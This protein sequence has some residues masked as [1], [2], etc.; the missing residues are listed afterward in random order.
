MGW[1][2]VVI[3]LRLIDFEHT[4]FALPFAYLGAFLAVGGVPTA[5][6]FWWITAAMVGARTAALA[7]NRLIDRH[8]DARNPRTANWILPRGLIGLPVVYLAIVLSLAL[9]FI[10]AAHLNP[11]CLKLAPA[12]VF[13]LVIYSYTKRFTWA[14]HL[15]LGFAIGLGPVG[16]WIAITARFDWPAILLGAAVALWVAGFD[17][18]YACQDE[19]FDRQEG[20]YSLPARFGTART[21]QITAGFHLFTVLLLVAVG[22]TLGLGW[23]YYMGVGIAAGVLIYEHL[24]V[25]P[26]DLSK[27]NTAAFRLNRY[28]ST[29]IFVFTLV[30]M[31]K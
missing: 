2:K 23:L 26:G 1:N 9:L 28:V 11:L 16:S 10:A 8:I 31:F 20:L 29:I 22:V 14:C 27:M 30:D 4:L 18:M 19:E 7:L 3:F 15:V 5:H 21:L 17:A 13:V 12:A 25:S 6:D 24:L